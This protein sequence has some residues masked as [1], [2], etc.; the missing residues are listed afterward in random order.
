MIAA[1]PFKGFRAFGF[2]ELRLPPEQA[3]H[4]PV[5][6]LVDAIEAFSGKT[7]EKESNLAQEVSERLRLKVVGGSDAHSV[8]E[9]G[10][11]VTIFD[12]NIQTEAE[13]ITELKAGRFHAGYFR[14]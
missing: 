3:S 4:R 8:G 6:Q 10:R 1:H 12:N 13:L 11:C 2:S 14:K 9:I 7:T 5:F